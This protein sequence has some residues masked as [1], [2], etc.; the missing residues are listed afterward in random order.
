MAEVMNLGW[1]CQELLCCVIVLNSKEVKK[2]Y[3]SL[4][5]ISIDDHH[6]N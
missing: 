2:M 3:L 1:D 6:Y 5:G 4:K